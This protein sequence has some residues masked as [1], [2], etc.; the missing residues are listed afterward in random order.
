MLYQLSYA[1]PSTRKATPESRKN[2]AGTVNLR[3]YYGTE[4]KVSTDAREEQTEEE[5]ESR[6]Y[7]TRN[8]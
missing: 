7:G 6:D 1:S 4:I 5:A 8:G 3:T 2:R